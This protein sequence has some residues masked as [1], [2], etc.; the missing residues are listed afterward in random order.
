M[1]CRMTVKITFTE[2]VVPDVLAQAGVDAGMAGFAVGVDEAI[3]AGELGEVNGELA[4]L[5]G[6]QTSP[7]IETLRAAGR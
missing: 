6:R 1:T 7:L 4:R 2:S 5:I 3:A